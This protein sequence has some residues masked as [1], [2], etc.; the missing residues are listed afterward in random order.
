MVCAL[1]AAALGCTKSPENAQ[2]VVE[3]KAAWQFATQLRDKVTVEA[4]TAHLEKLQDI[5][6]VH[7]G[8]RATGTPGYDASVDYV[9]EVLR[10]RGFDVETPEF[11][12][13]VF[14]HGDPDLSVGGA[15]VKAGVLKY[16][17]GTPE[18]GVSGPLVAAPAE[19]TPGCAPADYEGLS[20]Q[21]AVV[22]VDRGGCP[23]S[24][25]QAIAA[26]L[27]A[28]AM[29]VANNS[30]DENLAA[31]LGE[32]TNVGIPVVSVSKTDGARL[33]AKPGTAKV[34]LEAATVAI[35][36][37]NVIAQTKT[38]SQRNVVMVGGHL[39]SVE[40]GAGMNDN[41]SGVSAVL[42]TAVQLGSEPAV[43]NAVRFAFWGAEEVG[44]VGSRKY[45]S[46]LDAEQLK[47]IAL[48][49][50]F[51]MIGSPNPGYFAHDG[52]QST[53]PGRDEAPPLIPEGTAGIERTLVE[54]LASS[55]KVAQDAPFDNRS[56]Y[57]WFTLAGIPAGGLFSG[58]DEDKSPQQ[59]QL[60]GGTANA[61]FDADYHKD[62]DTLDKISREALDINGGGVAY[63][64]GLYATDIDGRNGI[65][66][67]EDRTRHEIPDQ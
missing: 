63:A 46:E 65:P 49:L 35:T 30:D 42:E 18:Y 4:M 13:R 33:R 60:W 57:T 6:N 28:V 56:D 34:T 50:N 27:G 40:E 53:P 37:R 20:V 44:I 67:R 19:E 47:D 8:T 7:G 51:D 66:A 52:D 54:Y 21:G 25:K 15:A 11:E 38:G 32:N 2:P 17:A 62:T 5:A 23:F 55:G 58:A 31:T 16:S 1:V 10:D 41:G 36:T 48:Y 59:A 29:V 26:K 14:Q 64:V 9:V 12:V 43:T 22:L 24:E 45:V 61:P 3:N 39:D